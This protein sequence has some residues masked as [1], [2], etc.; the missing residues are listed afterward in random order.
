MATRL[1]GRQFEREEQLTYWKKQL[2]A[3]LT[4]L[5]WPGVKPGRKPET[6]VGAILPFEVPHEVSDAAG[7]LARREGASMFAVLLSGF[8]TV[9]HGHTQQDDIVIGTL[10]PAGRKRTEC[11]NLLGYFLNPVALRF[12]FSA[13]PGFRELLS[14]TRRILGEAISHDDLP[15]ESVE[16]AL[17]LERDRG[18]FVRTAISLQPKSPEF[19]NGWRVTTMDARLSGSRWDFYLAFIQREGE[20]EGRV[21]YNPALFE[22]REIT[23]TLEE[24]F[25]VLQA[26][27]NGTQAGSQELFAVPNSFV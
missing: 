24:L 8:A 14:Q 10:S 12:D 21:Q 18:S 16:Q 7:C 23:A 26:A 6:C 13:K 11:Q 19:E 1:V 20:M 25:C 17:G 5:R 15:L 2:A 22:E 9:M 4:D 27:A 3:P